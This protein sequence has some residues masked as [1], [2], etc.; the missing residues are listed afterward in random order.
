MKPTRVW[1]MSIPTRAMF[2]FT[3]KYCVF[4]YLPHNNRWK[5]FKYQN[6][7]RQNDKLIIPSTPS[8]SISEAYRNNTKDINER[9]FKIYSSSKHN[10]Y[11]QWKITII[12]QH[13][14]ATFNSQPKLQCNCTKIHLL[15]EQQWI[16]ANSQWK[17]CRTQ[18]L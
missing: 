13:C 10:T 14:T 18:L 2:Q 15:Y 9:K 17:G 8:S 12:M 7:L 4:T 5:F 11:L 16:Y 1:S 6:S 3:C